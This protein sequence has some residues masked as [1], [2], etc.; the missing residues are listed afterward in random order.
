MFTVMEPSALI[1]H[2]GFVGS[3]LASQ[4]SFD[5]YFRST[6]VAE[7]AGR[8][9]GLVVCAGIQAKKWWANQNPEA[10]W[11]GIQTLLNVLSTVSAR[12]FVLISTVDVYPQR[13]GVDEESLIN[14]DN[15]HAYGK[16]RFQA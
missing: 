8:D 4:F 10:D 1:G 6:N 9:Y 11:F 7:M 5:D 3:N 12:R 2:T 13:S 15:N 14:P 16:H